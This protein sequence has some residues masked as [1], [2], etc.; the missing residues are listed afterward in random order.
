MVT[1]PVLT[2]RVPVDRLREVDRK[3]REESQR[4][5]QQSIIETGATPLWWKL[6]RNPRFRVAVEAENRR[7]YLEAIDEIAKRRATELGI[8][9]R[10]EEEC[11]ARLR[12]PGRQLAAQIPENLRE[13]LKK[14][15]AE[16]ESGNTYG[17]EANLR[18]YERQFRIA[19]ER[20]DRLILLGKW[21]GDRLRELLR[22]IYPTIDLSGIQNHVHYGG[23]MMIIGLERREMESWIRH[24]SL[25]GMNQDVGLLTR[26]IQ[27]KWGETADPATTEHQ[28]TYAGIQLAGHRDETALPFG[29]REI[30]VGVLNPAHPWAA[31]D[32]TNAAQVLLPAIHRAFAQGT[33]G[34]GQNQL[35]VPQGGLYAFVTR[36]I[37]R[38]SNWTFRIVVTGT[39]I[40]LTS[41]TQ[42][43]GQHSSLLALPR[44]GKGV[45][46]TQEG[47]LVRTATG[48][49]FIQGATRKFTL[50]PAE[51]FSLN[52]AA[53]L[54]IYFK[55]IDIP[56]MR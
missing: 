12:A 50:K 16:R 44:P 2:L 3:M 13:L 51:V 41:S 5:L 52:P 15:T 34:T 8:L 30:D 42:Q 40:I 29:H 48:T 46:G 27:M 4:L 6:M 1:G 7:I 43:V 18:L 55:A 25:W 56:E 49:Y 19:R 35:A 39:S 21:R 10:L 17:D 38:T 22:V 36:L 14:V 9:Q 11:Q 53:L 32:N 26:T 23:D 20:G 37:I 24:L 47:T 31:L 54:Y 28:I 33:H 45:A